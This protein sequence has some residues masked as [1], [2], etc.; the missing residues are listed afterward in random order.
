MKLVIIDLF[1]I[2]I[3][4]EG[5]QKFIDHLSFFLSDVELVDTLSQTPS[6]RKRNLSSTTPASSEKLGK[7]HKPGSPDGDNQLYS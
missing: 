1:I 7:C 6:L 4:S 2:H 5:I 3:S